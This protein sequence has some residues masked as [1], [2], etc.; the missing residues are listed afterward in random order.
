MRTPTPPP[1]ID[2]TPVR[3]VLFDLDDTLFD[4]RGAA[5][6]GVVAW[7]RALGLDEPAATLIER[8]NDLER[9]HFGNFAA[10]R[11]TFEQMRRHR[12]RGLAGQHLT[13]A[14]ADA[15]F[16]SFYAHY[17]DQW[18][19]FGDALPALERC[20][21]AGYAIGILTNGDGAHQRRKVTD[22]G[23]DERMDAIIISGE[24]GEAKPAPAI[25]HHA[26]AALGAAPEQTLM[27]GDNLPG[28]VEGARAAGLQGAWLDRH[29][30]HPEAISTL[31]A[32][33]PPAA[34]PR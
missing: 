2:W 20:R 31:D 19:L 5:D 28:D 24:F 32:L 6:A 15:A 33:E 10:G 11:E 26:C 18:A 1:A 8:W 29:N 30:R 12:A 9:T 4:H 34:A 25:F 14:Q 3:A 13:D 16:E 17:R 21:A 22:L 27:V 23:L 7:A